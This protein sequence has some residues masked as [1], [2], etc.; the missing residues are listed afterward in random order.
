MLGAIKKL[1]TWKGFFFNFYET[2][3]L[4]VPRKFV[5]S[6]DNGWLAIAL[7]VVRQA[8]PGDIATEATAILERFHFQEFLDPDTNHLAIGYD[9]EHQSPTPYHYGMLVTEARA[10]MVTTPSGAM[11]RK[12]CGVRSGGVARPCAA[13]NGDP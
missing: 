12:A 4:S 7:V 5:S 6:V 13:A 2:T 11:W 1:E 3:R 8:F 9:V 10:M